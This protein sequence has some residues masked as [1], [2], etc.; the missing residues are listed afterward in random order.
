MSGSNTVDRRIEIPQDVLVRELQGESVLLNLESE[1]YFGLDEV[2]TRMFR[3]LA[4]TGRVE[5]AFEAL[6]SEYEVEPESLRADLGEFVDRLAAAG[7]L[8]V[9]PV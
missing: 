4:A 7:L 8:R 3:A 1:S 2:G 6:L 5:A 9:A